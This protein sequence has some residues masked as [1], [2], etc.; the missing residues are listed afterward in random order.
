[1]LLISLRSNMQVLLKEAR[2]DMGTYC[3]G[4]TG[5]NNLGTTAVLYEEAGVVW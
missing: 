5:G 1:M 4:R 2:G 3:I